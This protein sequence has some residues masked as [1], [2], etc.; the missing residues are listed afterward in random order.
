MGND[1]ILTPFSPFLSHWEKKFMMGNDYILTPFLSHWENKFCQRKHYESN[2]CC[3]VQKVRKI[4]SCFIW[5]G[6]G[7]RSLQNI[8]KKRKKENHRDMSIF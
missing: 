7:K 6:G 1:Y 3:T 5:G 4:Y 2:L 8:K